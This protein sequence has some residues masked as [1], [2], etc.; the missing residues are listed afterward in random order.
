MDKTVYTVDIR[1][2][3]GFDGTLRD[4]SYVA[5]NEKKLNSRV[6]DAH[7]LDIFVYDDGNQLRRFKSLINK[8][9]AS[10]EYIKEV[11]DNGKKETIKENMNTNNMNTN[12]KDALLESAYDVAADLVFKYGKKTHITEEDIA[13]TFS[14]AIEDVYRSEF[15][16]INPHDIS[17]ESFYDM[18]NDKIK[19]S[20]DK[21]LSLESIDVLNQD[22]LAYLVYLLTDEDEKTLFEV[23]DAL[24]A[25]DYTFNSGEKYAD[26]TPD[27]I[28]DCVSFYQGWESEDDKDAA[29]SV[30]VSD[31]KQEYG[32]DYIDVDNNGEL[33]DEGF[34]YVKTEDII[35]ESKK[36][37]RE[38]LMRELESNGRL[39]PSVN[40]SRELAK[41]SKA[42]KGAK[43]SRADYRSYISA[44]KKAISDDIA[45]IK[46]LCGKCPSIKELSASVSELDVKKSKEAG[47]KIAEAVTKKS[48]ANRILKLVNHII[49]CIENIIN[50]KDILDA[51]KKTNESV[52][53]RFAAGRKLF[54]SE[55]G[56]DNKENAEDTTSDDAN[57]EDDK[58]KDDNTNKK[59]DDK[60]EDDEEVI[61]GDRV[62]ITFT[63][64]EGHERDEVI[65]AIKK[66]LDKAGISEEGI[67]I[68]DADGD[69]SEEIQVIV[70]G[71]FISEL[72]SFCEEKG[73][74][75][76]EKLGGEIEI[77]DKEGDEKEDNKKEDDNKDGNGDD[78]GLFSADMLDD[79]FGADL[80][81]ENGEG[82]EK[83]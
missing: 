13:E 24:V 41:P 65:E 25:S 26:I 74:D 52:T 15:V 39:V 49:S 42:P 1:K 33:L 29:K 57:K 45:E 48:D 38:E 75:L 67:E 43:P 70:D 3:E 53:S 2:L 30:A 47:D 56:E 72:K 7:K 59:E 76:E 11:L 19:N 60:K 22:D 81:D 61:D 8:Y 83:K 31:M 4:F 63:V 10:D 9:G 14:D 44:D 51:A 37:A 55:E 16:D 27:L 68:L 20:N 17:W 5:Y 21:G 66:D 69:E 36:E 73:V 46:E 28:P 71:D 78:D 35:N 82:E 58:K 18:V 32:D 54:E 80:N 50:I 12:T 64:S 79:I 77:D 23:D 6:R 34:C 62:K 40:E